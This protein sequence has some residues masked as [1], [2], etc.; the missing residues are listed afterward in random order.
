MPRSARRPVQL[1]GRIFSARYA[2]ARG[3]LTRDDLSSTAWRRVFRGV[4]ADRDLHLSHLLRI[5]AA[6]KHLLPGDAVIAGRSAAYLHGAHI[7]PDDA[8][9]EIISPEHFGPMR[10]IKSHSGSL[11][12]R[13]MIVTPLGLPVTTPMR[14]C[15]DL[16]RWLD[17]V[18][19]VVLIDIL[20][21]KGAVNLA[22]LHAYAQ[23]RAG[24]R[25]WRRPAK[26]VALADGGAESPQE[27]RLR[28]GFLLSGLPRPVTQ[29]T[30]FDSTGAFIARVDLAW[31]ELKIAVEYDGLWHAET[32]QFNRDRRRLNALQAAGWLVIHVTADRLRSDLPAIVDEIRRA[33]RTRRKAH[34]QSA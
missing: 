18:E 15:W 17:T 1:R 22:E 14:T 5:R 11:D 13:D 8:D 10:G 21:A 20:L 2:I 32:T 4:Y 9:V 28:I 27:T 3:L 30:I 19:A 25:G 29:H 24:M 6:A 26:A 34:Q 33:M 23:S 12:H 16:A 31:P 7:V